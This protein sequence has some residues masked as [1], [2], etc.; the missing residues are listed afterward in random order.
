MKLATHVSF[1]GNCEAAFKFYEKAIGARI[2]FLMH[3]EG[4]PMAEGAPPEL[5]KKVLHA[6][7]QVG[8][9]ELSGDDFP[10]EKRWQGFTLTLHTPDPAQAEKLFNALAERGNITLPLKETFWAIAFGAVTDQFGI[11]WMVN[12]EK[13]M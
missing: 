3:F 2:K 10:G 8:D 9:F 6:T 11:P 7:L 13:P 12:C 1:N 4:S 5:L